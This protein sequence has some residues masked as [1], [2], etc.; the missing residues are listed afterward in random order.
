MEADLSKL[1]KLLIKNSL[2][3]YLILLVLVFSHAAIAA[4]SPKGGVLLVVG[5]SLSAAH[6]LAREKGWVSLM[7]QRVIELGYPLVIV[8]KS[9]SGAT[10]QNGVDHLPEWLEEVH[11]THVLLALGSNDGLRGLY[12]PMMKKNLEKMIMISQKKGAQVILVGFMIPPNHGPD[13]S[14]A[15][16]KIFPAVAKEQDLPFVPFLLEGMATDKKFFQDDALHPNEVAQPI[17][18]E[19]VWK[20]LEPIIKPSSNISFG[21]NRNKY[22]IT[23][24]NR[25]I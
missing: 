25:C 9:V 23:E 15:F 14:E 17:L 10:T 2:N 22:I 13:Y 1:I 12:L 11:P 3:K 21:L 19:N 8:N 20:I 5:D 24:F 7:N 6:G 4:E 16:K 18:L